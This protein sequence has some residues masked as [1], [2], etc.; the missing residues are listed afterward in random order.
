[1]NNENQYE[2]DN[3]FSKEAI[4]AAA[5]SIYSFSK[6]KIKKINKLEVEIIS[7]LNEALKYKTVKNATA[8]KVFKAHR[9][10]LRQLWPKYSKQQHL[11]FVESFDDPTQPYFEY[12]SK[13]TG[14]DDAGILLKEIVNYWSNVK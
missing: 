13:N 1:M 11:D 14:N 12:Y 9:S 6:E 8:E 5:Q 2:L 4:D 10:W 7:G 3:L